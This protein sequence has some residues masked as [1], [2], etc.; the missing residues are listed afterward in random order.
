MSEAALR[1]VMARPAEELAIPAVE[2]KDGSAGAEPQ[3]VDEI[4]RLL[5][6][7]LDL[8]A[9]GQVLGNVKTWG[10]EVGSSHALP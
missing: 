8:G 3:H 4:I 5:R 9:R 1:E 2:Q 6:I 7:E 10:S